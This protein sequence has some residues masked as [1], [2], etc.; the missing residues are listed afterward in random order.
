[1]LARAFL[2]L[3]SIPCFGQIEDRLTNGEFKSLM[4]NSLRRSS[5]RKQLVDPPSGDVTPPPGSQPASSS[6]VLSVMPVADSI[7]SVLPERSKATDSL[8][9]FGKVEVGSDLPPST[10]EHK[11]NQ[12]RNTN[13][14]QSHTI[15]DR[16]DNMSKNCLLYTSPS[17]RDKRQSRMPSSA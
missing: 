11:N 5:R 4:V 10:A 17:P 16:N 8:S 2:L 1:M 6:G 14:T 7:D 12:S 3:L 15:D 9:F 13:N